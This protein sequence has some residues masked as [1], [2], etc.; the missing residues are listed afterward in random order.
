MFERDESSV[1][2]RRECRRG[3]GVQDRAEQGYAFDFPRVRVGARE[4]WLENAGEVEW[5][6]GR[7]E[8]GGDD[9]TG[10]GEVVFGGAQLSARE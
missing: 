8:G 5:V 1:G 2:T 3:E 7:G 4:D 10:G 9:G 6:E